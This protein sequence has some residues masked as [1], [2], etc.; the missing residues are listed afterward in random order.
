VIYKLHS[1]LLLVSFVIVNGSEK[2]YEELVTGFDRL[3]SSVIVRKIEMPVMANL[4]FA[5]YD[6]NPILN[7]PAKVKLKKRPPDMV[8]DSITF[9]GALQELKNSLSELPLSK[10]EKNRP[11]AWKPLL[12]KLWNVVK[13]DR[14][15]Q[16]TAEIENYK[17]ADSSVFQPYQQITTAFISQKDSVPEIWIKIEFSPWVKFLKSVD[18]EDRDGI[19]EVYGRLDTD[20][21][22]PDSLKKAAFW[23]KN[24]YCSKVLDRSE[25]VDWVTDLASYWYP[26]RNTDL[27]EISAGESWPGKDTGKK[28][29]KEMKK[30]F[31]TDP[32]AVMEGKPFS[33]DK[34]VYNV[35]VV[36]F[37]EIAKS[38]SVEPDFSSG[39]YD[40]SVSQNFTA[41]RIRFQ[42]EVKESGVYESQE[43]KNGSFAIALKN[44][45][46]SVPPDQMAFEGRDGWLFF[47]KSLESLLSGDIILQA[48]DKNP[49]PHLSMFHRYLKSHGV[50]MLFVVVP[51][52]EEVYFDKFP[53]GV[54]D[55][56]SGYANP[57]NRKVL[58][59]LQDSGVEVIDLLPLF[60][61]EKK[62][63]SILKEP[64]F[65][66]QDT[67]WTTRGL[68]IAAEAISKRVKTYAWYDNPDESRFV[69]IDTIVNRVGDLVE[70]LPAGRQPLY[71][72]MTLEAVQVRKNDGSLLKGNRFSPILL[73]GDSFTG[74]FESI[75]CK[76]AGVGSH[77]ASKTGL[78][79]E[80]ITSWGGG[81]L[82]RKKAMSSREKDLDKKR[83]VVY[84][85][86]ARDLFNYNQGWEKFPE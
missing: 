6:R 60:L 42:N 46:N 49:L 86:S 7:D 28:A 11:L 70:R 51:N 67:H 33:P 58:A 55:S 30:M 80:V 50:N 77:I 21:I 4:D 2:P 9:G 23:I 69:K 5:A 44:W 39:T 3:R 18:D 56:L 20:D 74:A 43:E 27:L 13:N 26:T 82:V 62:N 36:Q 66:K 17:W 59:D 37:P 45:L 75:D 68:K 85:M 47:R 65:Q 35:F 10:E 41:N 25:A 61:Q 79:V 84:M 83:L 40:S 53:E 64:L 38:E 48:E 34:P 15:Q 81:P 72:P 32:L 54:S 57:F 14:L 1:L 73:I 24:E 12:K 8:L 63:G 78:E 71:G 16:I 19:K 31:V 22:N 29:K 52:K 76:S